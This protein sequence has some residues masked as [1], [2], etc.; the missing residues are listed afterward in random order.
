MIFR[1]DYSWGKSTTITQQWS[2][3]NDKL[4]GQTTYSDIM[5]KKKK[6]L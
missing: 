4:F 2:Q 6:N 5:Q 1:E 3:K